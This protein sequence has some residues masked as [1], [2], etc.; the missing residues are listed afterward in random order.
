MATCD[1]RLLQTIVA[2]SECLSVCVCVWMCMC[3]DGV[4]VG[5]WVGIWLDMV[6]W[7]MVSMVI[8][9]GLMRQSLPRAEPLMAD[10]SV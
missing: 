3:V 1:S 7:E 5:G 9:L 2:G 10:V 4:W 8:L 6:R